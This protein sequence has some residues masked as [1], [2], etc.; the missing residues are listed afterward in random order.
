MAE[1]PVSGVPMF[2]ISSK[3][4]S[5]ACSNRAVSLIDPILREL[6][7]ISGRP[8]NR[9]VLCEIRAAETKL[10]KA[11]SHPGN[12]VWPGVVLKYL[13]DQGVDRHLVEPSPAPEMAW[14]SI[15]RDIRM[16]QQPLT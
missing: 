1:N 14:A 9:I 8:R 2:G 10:G 12:L 4:L 11:R 3:A 13:R 16:V 15:T 6:R 5:R 7:V